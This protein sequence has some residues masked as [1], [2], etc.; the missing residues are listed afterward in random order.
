M[1][2]L[3]K[4]FTQA[5]RSHSKSY[6]NNG[7]F[8]LVQAMLLIYSCLFSH[9]AKTRALPL[10]AV[11]LATLPA[12]MAAFNSYMGL[13]PYCRNWGFPDAWQGIWQVFVQLMAN[14]LANNFD[15]RKVIGN[16]IFRRLTIFAIN[17]YS[18]ILNFYFFTSKLK[19]HCKAQYRQL[20]E[21]IWRAIRMIIHKDNVVLFLLSEVWVFIW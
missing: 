19:F 12:K 6:T 14:F 9:S 20:W 21:E 13:K 3:I 2:S 11:T 16:V 10:S 4:L 8:K 18:M 15:N 5:H 1:R 17:I 7:F